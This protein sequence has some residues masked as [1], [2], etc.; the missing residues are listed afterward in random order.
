[1]PRKAT[2]KTPR[3]SEEEEE[4]EEEEEGEERE[5]EEEEETTRRFSPRLTSVPKKPVSP[6]SISA[7]DRRLLLRKLFSGRN[8]G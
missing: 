1:V 2:E 6:V 5:E 3:L 7:E 4:V 8:R